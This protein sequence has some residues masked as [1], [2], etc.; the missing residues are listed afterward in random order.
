MTPC[1]RC[2]E[3]AQSV[4]TTAS[5]DIPVCPFCSEAVWS[6]ETFHF[7]QLYGEVV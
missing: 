7:E 2:N 5:G 1:A 3:E 4:I 6:I